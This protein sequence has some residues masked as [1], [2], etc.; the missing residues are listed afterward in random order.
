MD[1]IYTAPGNAGTAGLGHNLDISPDDTEGLV[2]VAKGKRIELVVVGPEVPLAN[3]IVDRFQEDG[4]PVFGPNQQAARIESSKVFAKEIMQKYGIPCAASVSFSDYDRAREY[5]EQQKAPMW[6]K[7]D[8]LAAGKGAIFAG[9][10]AEALEVLDDLMKTRALG[11]AG[12]KIVIEESLSGNEMSAFAFTDGR[13]VIPMVSACDYKRINDGD[14]GPNTGGMGSFSPPY[15]LSPELVNTV[16]EKIMVAAVRAMARENAPYRGVLYG[17]VM[18]TPEGPKVLEFNARFGDP[19]TQVILPRL[20]TDLIDIMLAV[21]N[22]KLEQVKMEWSADACVGVVMASGGYPGSYKTG[23]PVEGLDDL[24][25]GIEVFHAGT[26]ID[27]ESGRVVTSGGRVLTV[28][29]PGRNIAEA[30]EKVYANISRIKFEGCQYRS[31][32][33]LVKEG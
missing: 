28:V 31:D 16:N 7:A 20:K 27:G 4:I 17:G 21:I 1:E 24:D 10:T 13:T 30:R 9:S 12:D 33:A 19:E 15:F 14:R 26:K 11:A 18:V 2:G 5:I 32:I 22:G 23:F 8:G 6:V 29:A 3:G 25:D